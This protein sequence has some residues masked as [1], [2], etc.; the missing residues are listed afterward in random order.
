MP[1][2]VYRQNLVERALNVA[3]HRAPDSTRDTVFPPAKDIDIRN[4]CYQVITASDFVSNC[5]GTR[6]KHSASL[7]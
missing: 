5:P 6:V 2:L 4:F 7:T 3:V 1:T